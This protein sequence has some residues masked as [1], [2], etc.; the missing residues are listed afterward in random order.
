MANTNF[1]GCGN[2][3]PIV[4]GTNPA[5]QTWNGQAFVVADGSLQ[6]PIRLPF[7]K[8]NSGAATYV[9]GADNNGNWS[10][11]N[12]AYSGYAT[13]LLGGLAGQLPI[14]TAPSTTSFIY[15]NDVNVTATGSTTARTLANRFADIVNVKDFGAIGDGV[16]DDTAA[17]QAAINYC[18]SFSGQNVL[19]TLVF[20][21]SAKQ[22]YFILGTLDFTLIRT[23]SFIVE[24]NGSVI[25][26][27][28]SG[29]P[30]IDALGSQ[31]ISF[32]NGTI[33]GFPTNT[34]S[35]GIQIGRGI[36]GQDAPNC[37]LYNIMIDGDF[38]KTS[39]LNA[40]S[41]VFLAEKCLFWNS[42]GSCLIQDSKNATNVQ[43][44]FFTVTVPQNV[45]QSLND[46]LYLNCN[47][48][49]IG[50]TGSP[51]IYVTSNTN[52]LR[53]NTCYAQ[54][55]NHIVMD[56]AGTHFL[57]EF[58]VHCEPV[59]VLNNVRVLVSSVSAEFD[60]CTFKEY[61]MFATNA[62]ITTD[63]GSNPVTFSN[64]E[65]DV[66]GSYTT[67][68][69]FTNAG[70]VI[71][72]HGIIK[73]GISGYLYNLS[74]LNSINAEIFCKNVVS[75]FTLPFLNNVNIISQYSN[76]F[77]YTGAHKFTGSLL[78]PSGFPS[79][80]TSSSTITIPQNGFSFFVTGTTN[81]NKINVN[82]GDDGRLV[83]L[84]FGGALT[85]Q[86][87]YSNGTLLAGNYATQ[88]NYSILLYCNGTVW[89][90]LS[91]S[92]NVAA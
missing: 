45:Q 51:A 81:I 52:A 19:P 23:L 65:I 48:E 54:N 61:G 60:G 82:P 3:Y 37:S 77:Q 30:V 33:Y 59:N 79:T 8:V 15:P 35:I 92:N 4:P 27:K 20:D 31:H 1:C 24:L 88:A 6:N 67:A 87:N 32:R 49:Q 57:L 2:Q 75:N 64:C 89:V 38:T 10:Y 84:S 56:I 18:R 16:T 63:G 5:L 13:N 90:E 58:D 9:V 62:L 17:I 74:Q 12:P 85:L 36:I 44:Q 72:Y 46:N 66:P 42:T 11:Y 47:F 78:F 68:P 22:N 86:N 26:A 39:F 43:S 14:Q 70:S 76:I 25:T 55:A 7:L 53:F 91:R 40:G 83:Q 69:L 80:I 21:S 50:N 29:K 71:D 41:E 28:T 34:P 73:I